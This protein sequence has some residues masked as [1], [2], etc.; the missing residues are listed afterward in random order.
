MYPGG[1][2]VDCCIYLEVN[3]IILRLLFL[4]LSF[5]GYMLFFIKQCRIEISFAPAISASLIMLMVFVGGI[6]GAL[7]ISAY[8][9]FGLGIALLI[10]MLLKKAPTD[11]KKIITNPALIFLTLAVIYLIFRFRNR[12]LYSY[13]DFSH[14]GIIL[15]TFFQNDCLPSSA[16]SFILF[17]SYPPGSACWIYFVARILGAQESAYLLAQSFLVLAYLSVLFVFF[18][19]RRW[20]DLLLTLIGIILIYSNVLK[21]TSLSVDVL[22]AA[23]GLAAV[24][25]VYRSRAS[26][27]KNTLILL[28]IICSPLL[29][30]NSGVFFSFIS[31]SLCL[32]YLYMQKQETPR[33]RLIAGLVLLIVPIALLLLWRQHVAVSFSCG[34]ASKHALSLQNF[35]SRWHT[36]DNHAIVMIKKI[37]LWTI[38]PRKDFALL[39]LTGFVALSAAEAA[40]RRDRVTNQRNLTWIVLLSVVTAV[41]ELG[42]AGMYLFS[43][44]F[45]EFMYQNGKD[46]IRYNSTLVDFLLGVLLVWYSEKC[47][48]TFHNSDFQTKVFSWVLRVGTFALLLGCL[49][50]N[51][52]LQVLPLTYRDE[53]EIRVEQLHEALDT[54]A[55]PP[56]GRY[57]V[58]TAPDV[59]DFSFYL[60]QYL[61]FSNN[62]TIIT[63]QVDSA[64]I[65][66]LV[67][68]YTAY[69]DWE[70]DMPH[71]YTAS[72]LEE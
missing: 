42:I 71:V 18:E 56:K 64:Q 37:V 63:D 20:Y 1:E 12:V 13:D 72:L 23:S 41:Y 69:I 39:V 59:A 14:W 35:I 46:Y 6:F 67:S 15:K 16:N 9:L 34:L 38:N 70:K 49:L 48:P 45:S 8:L 52:K 30:K 31:V 55:L 65:P 68:E 61:L 66:M 19:N 2:A 53:Q 27:T 50:P 62:V 40:L 3:M 25:V 54:Q 32:Y 24:L 11:W 57:L 60:F 51:T 10:W 4:C 5:L 47:V 21:P 28:P 17:Q 26:L 58:R 33:K 7:T 44:P 43:M 36:N 22:L 29:I